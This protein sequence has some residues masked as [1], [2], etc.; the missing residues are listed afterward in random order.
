MGLISLIG[1]KGLKIPC[2]TLEMEQKIIAS[3]KVEEFLI[4][5]V[6]RERAANVYQ[7]HCLMN[8]I[9][10]SALHHCQQLTSDLPQQGRNRYI[11]VFNR[12]S[13]DS[14]LQYNSITM[15]S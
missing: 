1:L 2:L 7:V 12:R 15:L 5:K 9:S 11:V 14:R 8:V 10:K 3:S 6:V 4:H 13:Q